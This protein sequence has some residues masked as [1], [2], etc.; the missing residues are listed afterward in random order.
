MTNVSTKIKLAV[1][2]QNRVGKSG[3]YKLSFSLWVQ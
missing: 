3:I 2:G 1:V